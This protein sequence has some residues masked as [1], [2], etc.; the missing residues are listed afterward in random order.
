MASN[1]VRGTTLALLIGFALATLLTWS[2]FI[3]AKVANAENQRS[4]RRETFILPRNSLWM[5]HAALLISTM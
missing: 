4:G 5:D 2:L 3:Y 1:P